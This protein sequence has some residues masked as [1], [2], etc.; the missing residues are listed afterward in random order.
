MPRITAYQCRW[1][2]KVFTDREKYLKHLLK[3][4]PVLIAK[5]DSA[6]INRVMEQ[7]LATM[8]EECTTFS[9]IEEY[10]TENWPVFLQ[11]GDNHNQWHR[12]PNSP[13][14]KRP[15]LLS[16]KITGRYSEHVSNS[17]ASPIG[18]LQNWSREPGTPTG[19]PG[20]DCYIRF[21]LDGDTDSFCSNLFKD[22]GLNTG[23]GGGN[24]A[25]SGYDLKIYA[26]DWPGLE[27]GRLFKEL[28]AEW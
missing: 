19:Y 25:N 18:K 10:I 7:V 20:Y 1:T 17:H 21:S 15:K 6:R 3:Q 14:T 27:R 11:N 2:Q 8:R 4:R 5:R 24:H 28:R 13:P 9:E 22:T 16:I 12:R 23:S 26:D